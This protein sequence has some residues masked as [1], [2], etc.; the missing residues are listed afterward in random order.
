MDGGDDWNTIQDADQEEMLK[1]LQGDDSKKTG[2]SGIQE[3]KAKDAASKY[4][5][6]PGEAEAMQKRSQAT[7]ELLKK[8]EDADAPEA[9]EEDNFNDNTQ[10]NGCRPWVGAIKAPTW[11]KKDPNL[12]KKPDVKIQLEYL[13]GYRSK[14]CRNNVKYLKG[15]KMVYNAAG[16]AVV[17]DIQT[18]TQKFFLKH[19]DDV[20]AIAVNN[21]Q[22]LVATGQVS[23][24]KKNCPIYIWNPETLEIVQEIKNGASKG[25]SLLS[26]SPDGSKLVSLS[27]NDS[28]DITIIN[29]KTGAII[30]SS[31]GGQDK[32]FACEWR[33]DNIIVTAG[34]KHFRLW[35][36]TDFTYKRGIWGAHKCST[37]LISVA[38]NPLNKDI[39]VGAA[40]GTLQ[41]FK[42]NTC[43][44]VIQLHE[45]KILDALTFSE[46]YI[47]TGGRDSNLCIL[48]A[49][50]YKVIQK[51]DLGKLLNTSL[52]AKVRSAQ[53]NSDCSFLFVSTFGSE[54]Y[55]LKLQRAG[56]GFVVQ[57]FKQSMSGHYSPNGSWTN[58]VWGLDLFRD[59]HDL[60]VTAS[61]DSTIRVWSISQHK[62]LKG[63]SLN[64]NEKGEQLPLDT[65]NNNDFFDSSKARAVGAA[66]NGEGFLV[67]F[68]DGTL[69]FCDANLHVKK[70]FK[71]AKEWISTIKFSPKGNL[72][73]VGSHD[74]MIYLYSYPEFKNVHKLNKHT[75]FITHLDFSKDGSHIRSVCGA[76][77]LLFWDA[78]TGAQLTAGATQLRDEEWDTHSCIFSWP[79]QKMWKKSYNDYT[80]INWCDRSHTKI[81]GYYLLANGDDYSTVNLF[82][83]P[84]VNSNAQCIESNGHC[85]HITNIRFSYDDKY[86][87]TTGGEDN[88]ILI[89]RI[90]AN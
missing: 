30:K 6:K 22:T 82:R 36:A 10:A 2:E 67:G 12:S 4:K 41:I 60:F 7:H 51:I 16:A 48:D 81:N 13:H 43:E 15:G 18:N 32:L 85:S 79:V 69:R 8:G 54:I 45:A 58:E 31:S 19:T 20:T 44:K 38:I 25:C 37:R 57:A 59:N 77:D 27:C 73:A 84:C 3:K 9:G 1:Q 72:V 28:H 88:S 78:N 14:D 66:P 24:T 90:A 42:M 87:I 40:D 80:D 62:Q 71:H 5:L 56:E 86:L 74:N 64:V 39:L 53:F 23:D 26:F 89:W 35:N 55:Q 52:C 11:Y 65:K 76:Y 50:N 33:D 68:K 75:S 63:A 21:N 47:V 61:D 70:V 46:G 29:V 34:E 49:K 17:F 83:W